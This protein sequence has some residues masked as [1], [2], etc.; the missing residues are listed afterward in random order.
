MNIETFLSNISF[1]YIQPDSPVESDRIVL[2]MLN[3]VLPEDNEYLHSTIY[4][5]C[6]IPKMSTFAIGSIINKIVSQMKEDQ[7]F[8][9]VGVWHGYTFLSGIINNPIKK[10]IGIDN[11]SEFGGPREEFLQRFR[12]LSNENHSFHEID[13]IDYFSHVHQGEI[14]F[15]IYDGEHSY[16][17][18]LKGLQVAEPFFGDDCIIMID[19]TNWEQ[20]RKATFHFLLNSK[21]KY[22]VLADIPT[23]HDSHPTYWN[24]IILLKKI[25]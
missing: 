8:V 10:C 25:K 16:E 1:P 6:K 3:T 7:Y 4:Q 9:N 24:G 21:N 11:F 2:E 5:L 20:V 15:Y 14:G 22:Q 19:D 17:H 23:Q 13:Y 12:S 18:Q